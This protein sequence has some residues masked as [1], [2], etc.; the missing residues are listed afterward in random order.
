MMNGTFKEIPQP[1]ENGYPFNPANFKEGMDMCTSLGNVFPQAD[2]DCSGNWV[3]MDKAV[4]TKKT[5]AWIAQAAW[6]F[7][8]S[9]MVIVNRHIYGYM[10]RWF[11]W[12]HAIGGT[13]VL[14]LNTATTIY[15]L[16]GFSW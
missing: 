15:A 8:A 11:F 9:F 7:T 6:C 1:G 2:T 14:C 12:I 4:F 13:I 5:H 16:N 3:Y 10:W